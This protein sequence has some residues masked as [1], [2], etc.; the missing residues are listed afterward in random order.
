MYDSET[1]DYYNELQYLEVCKVCFERL[2]AKCKKCGKT[3]HKADLKDG[4]CWY[5][6]MDDK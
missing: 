1:D 5:C 3:F 2:S 6:L 4:L